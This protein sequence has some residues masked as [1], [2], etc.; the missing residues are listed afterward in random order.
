MSPSLFEDKVMGHCDQHNIGR[1]RNLRS[2]CA[3]AQ[4]DL[5]LLFCY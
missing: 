2:A 5:R 1:K 3:D 4:A